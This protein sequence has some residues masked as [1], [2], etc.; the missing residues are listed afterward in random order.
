MSWRRCVDW[1]LRLAALAVSPGT[2]DLT[3]SARQPALRTAVVSR[4][5]AITWT[6]VHAGGSA[7]A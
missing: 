2:P 6:S 1:L 3:A 4:R 5:E 7:R